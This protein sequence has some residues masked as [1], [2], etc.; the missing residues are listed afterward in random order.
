MMIM[1]PMTITCF[2]VQPTYQVPSCGTG[3]AVVSSVLD[4]LGQSCISQG[5]FHP[6][7]LLY[8]KAVQ[9]TK[10]VVSL[11]SRYET[12]RSEGNPLIVVP[13]LTAAFS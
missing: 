4:V 1:T 10:G 5:L 13:Y 3:S 2:F 11:V 8:F 9:G 7:S 6:S 12:N